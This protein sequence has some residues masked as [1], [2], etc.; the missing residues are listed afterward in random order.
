MQHRSSQVSPLGNFSH[1]PLPHASDFEPTQRLKM[2]RPRPRLLIAAS[3]TGGHVFPAIATAEALSDFEIEWLGVPDRLETKLVG[4]R[5]P[6]HSVS[7]TG[8][9]Q[10][11]GLGTLKILGRLIQSV[12]QVRSLLKQGKFAGVFTTGGYISGPA[13]LAARLLGLPVILHE[14]NALPGKVTRW[15]APWCT[16]TAIGFTVAAQ[17]L[18]KGKTIYVGTPLPQNCPT[19]PSRWMFP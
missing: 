11:L 7:V 8:F 6:F 13:I 17:R 5:Y 10:K 14:S 1:S 18:P 2:P 12:W 3:G 4:D 9:Q 19:C 15:F 16:A